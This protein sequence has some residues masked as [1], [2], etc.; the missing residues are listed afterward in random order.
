MKQY[1]RREIAGKPMMV[2]LQSKPAGPPISD[3]QVL[4]DIMTRMREY[5]K[6]EKW[7]VFPSIKRAA[8]AAVKVIEYYERKRDY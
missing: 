1:H 6:N 5:M 8:K 2:I 7:P 4:A 3:P